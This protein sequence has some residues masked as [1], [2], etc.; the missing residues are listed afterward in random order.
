[1][2]HSCTSHIPVAVL[3]PCSQTSVFSQAGKKLSLTFL[4]FALYLF[5]LMFCA[6]VRQLFVQWITVTVLWILLVPYLAYRRIRMKNPDNLI[7]F[8]SRKSHCKKTVLIRFWKCRVIL[9]PGWIPVVFFL[10]R[11]IPHLLIFSGV[12]PLPL[13]SLSPVKVTVP[14]DPFCENFRFR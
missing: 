2:A 10:A 5:V 11:L 4:M 7:W 6:W 14:R 8:W 3:P 12:K 13:N 9:C 1:M